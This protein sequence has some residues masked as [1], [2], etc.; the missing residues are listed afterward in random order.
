VSVYLCETC[1]CQFPGSAAGSVFLV[2]PDGRTD[3]LCSQACLRVFVN[4][5]PP[6]RFH[7]NDFYTA[8]T[9]LGVTLAFGAAWFLH[10]SP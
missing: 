7:W 6:K 2:N 10:C 1:N 4:R 3:H 8:A 9:V 5:R